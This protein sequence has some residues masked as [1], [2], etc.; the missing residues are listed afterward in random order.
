MEERFHALVVKDALGTLTRQEWVRLERHQVLRRS[1]LG[2]SPDPAFQ[3][4]HDW[5]FRQQ[6]KQLGA[7][8]RRHVEGQ[9]AFRQKLREILPPVETTD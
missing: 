6:M 3:A 1:Y 2:L 7:A 9:K 5:E 8:V 4:R